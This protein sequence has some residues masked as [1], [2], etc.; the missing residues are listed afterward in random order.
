LL[1]LLGYWYEHQACLGGPNFSLPF[2]HCL[3]T[4]EHSIDCRWRTLGQL[5][6]LPSLK[7]APHLRKSLTLSFAP[8]ADPDSAYS[9][10]GAIALQCA[11]HFKNYPLGGMQAKM[12]VRRLKECLLSHND[13]FANLRVVPGIGLQ[14]GVISAT[15]YG[16]SG[17]G[18]HTA[19]LYALS[20]KP[21]ERSLGAQEMFPHF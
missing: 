13:T 20:L 14:P 12:L 1:D 3:R 7:S 19:S 2:F 9:L 10:S 11:A 15:E 21:N 17:A 4:P 8:I 5:L 16:I 18:S 6:V